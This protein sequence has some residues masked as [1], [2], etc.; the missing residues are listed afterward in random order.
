[1]ISDI[2]ESCLCDPCD[3]FDW[4]DYE[5]WGILQIRDNQIGE[6]NYMASSSGRSSSQLDSKM[7]DPGKYPQ[8][9]IFSEDLPDTSNITGEAI[10]RDIRRGSRVNGDKFKH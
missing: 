5:F 8:N 2:C 4:G 7:E 3:C 10:S 6:D 9:R 1:M